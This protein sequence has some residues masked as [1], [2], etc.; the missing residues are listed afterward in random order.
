MG[1]FF[2][3]NGG[4]LE[5]AFE[6][7][8]EEGRWANSSLLLD[9]EDDEAEELVGDGVDLLLEHVEDASDIDSLGEH[10]ELD[11]EEQIEIGNSLDSV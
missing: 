11:K 4:E 9:K 10:D 2:E 3:L 7:D 8:D 5:S 1:R 6:D